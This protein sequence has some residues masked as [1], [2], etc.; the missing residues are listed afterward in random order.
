[1][2]RL[3]L[4]IFSLVIVANF[5]NTLIG[6]QKTA[7]PLT[8][9]TLF[10]PDRITDVEI[11]LDESDWDKIRLQGRVFSEALSKEMTENPFTYVKGN[12]SID[13]AMIKNV[14][15]RKKG[16]IGSLN[17]D[18]PSL[19]IKFSEYQD[20]SPVKGLDR[21]TLNNNNQDAGR[22][23]QYLAYK[24]FR[25]SGTHA[26]RCGFAKVTVNGTYLGIYSN[27]EAIKS[28]FLEHSFGGKSGAVYEGTVT[29]FYPEYNKKFEQKNKQ[30]K[31]KYISA[32]TEVLRSEELDLEE[33]ETLVDVD[34]F[35]KFWAMESLIGFWDGYCSN[36]NNYY[37]Y[38]DSKSKKFQFIP[39]GTDSAFTES[40]PIPPFFIKPI[41]VHAKAI[42][43][44]KLYRIDEV[45]TKYATTMM[46]F[47]DEHWNE[48]K[49]LAEVDRVETLLSEHVLPE[50][51]KS[52]SRT[53]LGYRKF[54][55]ARREAIEE[56]FESGPPKLMA[57]SKKPSYFLPI[58]EVTA[59]FKGIW[60]EKDPA[61]PTNV[62]EV[63][64]DLQVN[65]KAIKFESLG[66]YAKKDDRDPKSASII[67]TGKS[68]ATGKTIIIAAG[69]PLTNFEP[70]DSSMNTGGALIQPGTFGLIG[71]KFKMMFGSVQL[72]QAS[73]TPGEEFEGTFT[74]AVGEFNMN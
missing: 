24:L 51:K 6:K 15:I 26:P 39:W 14:G 58:G 32:V 61:N 65:G 46:S 20:Q 71:M 72:K 69:V 36:Q 18:R 34:S 73:L 5:P 45:K 22:I 35:I 50:N 68:S 12:V 4:F 47:L 1:M 37:L 60:C 3:F 16:F 52:F 11:Q 28:G 7:Q 40:S 74:M 25:D 59:T 27:V 54:I 19:K 30:A 48:T 31:S 64:V 23:C 56:E 10:A 62:G 66:V 2:N 33:L 57:E 63:T 43:P 70:S 38:R 9:E 67:I 55:E 21:L 49:L 13:G 42:L 29:D 53:L 41:S 44:N 8:A 17:N